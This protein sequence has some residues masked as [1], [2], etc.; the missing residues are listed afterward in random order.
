MENKKI[1]IGIISENAKNDGK[2]VAKLLERYFPKKGESWQISAGLYGDKIQSEK[3]IGIMRDNFKQNKCDVVIV[4]L[5]LD[6]EKKKDIRH[7][8]FKKC[9]EKICANSQLLLFV[10]MIEALAVTDFETTKMF[11][12]VKVSFKEKPNNNKQAKENLQKLFSY[13]ESDMDFLAEDFN[14]QIL[15]QNYPTWQTF[16]NEM[17]AVLNAEIAF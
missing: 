2:P 4:V 13:T 1:K 16:I 5:D 6:N 10:Y 8:F 15:Y 12:E 11:Y 7:D 3:S 17:A 9:C 14:K